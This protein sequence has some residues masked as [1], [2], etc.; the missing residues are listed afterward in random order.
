MFQVTPHG[1]TELLW[2]CKLTKVTEVS[3]CLFDQSLQTEFHR[4]YML[5]ALF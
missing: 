2:E 3:D 1:S 5:F 4:S